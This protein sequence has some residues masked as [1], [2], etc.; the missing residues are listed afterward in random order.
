MRRIL[1]NGPVCCRTRAAEVLILIFMD[2]QQWF[3]PDSSCPLYR[4][5]ILGRN[6]NK[7]LKSFPPCYSQ[8]PILTGSLQI[9]FVL[10][11]RKVCKPTVQRPNSWT[12]NWNKSL[13]SFPP[14]YS[15]SP[16]LTGF[17]GFLCPV[18]QKSVHAI[19]TVYRGQIL[20]RIWEK[21]L[22]VFLLSIHS[23]LY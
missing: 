21:V 8:S 22:G 18:Q 13:K 11:N 20:G 23:H 15:Q 4:G 16:L 7:S 12:G 14:C 5:R 9:S 10:C 17:L 2:V 3:P 19:C 6:W 1:F